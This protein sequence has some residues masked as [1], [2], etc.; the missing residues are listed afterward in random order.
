[1]MM[2]ILAWTT[3]ALLLAEPQHTMTAAPTPSNPTGTRKS[4]ARDARPG[5]IFRD[6]TGCPE[7]VVVPRGSF[8][9]GS[10]ASEPGRIHQEGPQRR[11]TV[12]QFAVGKFDVT[13]GQWRAFVEA[14]H[15]STSE[16]CDYSG[17][18]KD[19]EAWASWSNLGFPQEDSHPVVCVAWDDVQ[20]Y[21]HWLSKRT[22][23]KYRLLTEAEWGYAARGEQPRPIHGVR[24]GATST[25]TT[26]RTIAAWGSHRAVISG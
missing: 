17:L 8:V 13:R 12:R 21:L 1:M 23:R 18:P 3:A 14:T 24:A 6:C 16:G 26:G 7:M 4:V 2:V 22:G 10:P 9:M 5:E 20:D 25:P 19:K 15:R 11:V